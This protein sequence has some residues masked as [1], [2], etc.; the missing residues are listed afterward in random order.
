M[1][2]DIW[3]KLLL[4]IWLFTCSSDAF[5]EKVE[6]CKQIG[7]LRY[8]TGF[9]GI[10]FKGINQN[11]DEIGGLRSKRLDEYVE[12]LNR[13]SIN[14]GWVEIADYHKSKIENS[15]TRIA[16]VPTSTLFLAK[17][18][19]GQSPSDFLKALAVEKKHIINF[20]DSELAGDQQI[21]ITDEEY[22]RLAYLA[23]GVLGA[24][25]S[26][27]KSFEY[28]K[29]QIAAMNSGLEQLG[30]CLKFRTW[31]ACTSQPYT[32]RGL[33]QIKKVPMIG[34]LYG[35]D[36]DNLGEAYFAGIATV[37]F[38]IQEYKRFLNI[39]MNERRFYMAISSADQQRRKV[40]IKSDDFEIFLTYIYRGDAREIYDG[41][42]TP[43]KSCYY[44]RVQKYQE[45]LKLYIIP[46]QDCSEAG[47]SILE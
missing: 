41:T 30:V 9:G 24:E 4:S 42:A 3:S 28:F 17:N 44:K 37:G 38:L 45:Y 40:E 20:Y 33:T 32:S 21:S 47:S 19:F 10:L 36:R 26:A 5:A 16:V 8:Q 15:C 2:R 29:E 27:G 1:R 13:A 31:K 14:E 34:D 12:A 7:T 22:N 6:L 35:I 39:L 11:K 25:S 43:D 46:D 23:A 18:I